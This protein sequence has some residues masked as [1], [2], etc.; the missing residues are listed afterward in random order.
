MQLKISKAT[1]DPQRLGCKV[2]HTIL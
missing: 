2:N 1:P